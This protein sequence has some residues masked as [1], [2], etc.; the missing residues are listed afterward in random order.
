MG[1]SKPKKANI[2]DV[3]DQSTLSRFTQSSRQ[4]PCVFSTEYI[5]AAQDYRQVWISTQL[6][7]G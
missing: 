3:S 7:L 4:E 1:E 5:I 2:D 6:W